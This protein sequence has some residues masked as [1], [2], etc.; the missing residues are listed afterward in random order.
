[1]KI[2]LP[3]TNREVVVDD[4][5]AIVT[6]TDL[7]G[8]I[9]FVNPD[10]IKISGY[11]EQELLGQN[12]NIVRH[13]DMPPAAFAD[14]W[15][16]MD[17]GKPWSGIVKN[18]C[19]NGDHYWVKAHVA[20][21]DENGKTVGYTSMRTKPGRAEIEA[22][23]RLYDAI[24]KGKATLVD[25]KVTHGV[26]LSK[27]NVLQ[28]VREL[29]VNAQITLM[30]VSFLA[31]F[32]LVSV[33]GYSAISQVQVTGPIYKRVVQGKDLIADILPPPEYLIEA[34]QVSLDMMNSEESALPAM[35]EKSRALR[36][37]YESRHQFWMKDLPEGQLKT[38]MVSG[39]YTPGEEF[40]D[41][42]DKR[43]IPALLAGNRRA[44]EEAL[45]MM[46]KKYAEHRAMIDKVVVLA[47]QRNS[48]DEKDAAE[49]IGSKMRMLG[50][51]AAAMLV[52]MAVLGIT[53][54][55]NINSLLGGDPRYAREI[56]RHVASG[57]LALR[58]DIDPNDTNSLLASIK[59]MREMFRQVVKSTQDSANQVAQV[60]QQMAAASEQVNTIARQ[61]SESTASMAATTEEMT[62][63]MGLVV[64]NAH[65]AHSISVKS[66]E[67]CTSGVE[68]IQQAVHSMEQIAVTVR[69]SAE[70][71]QALGAQSEQISSVVKVIR[72]IADQTNLLALNAA[73][74]AARAG[75]QGRGFAV[76][77]DEVRKLAERTT[78]ATKD[79]TTMIG[80]I[81]DGMR[82][83]VDNMERGVQQVNSGV[84]EANEAGEAIHQ[85]QAGAQRVVQVVSDMSNSLREQGKASE[86]IAQSLEE[87]ARMTEENSAVAH[88]ASQGAHQLLSSAK[89]MQNTVNRF[90]A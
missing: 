61:S 69:E 7:K 21:M 25:G 70:V 24:N 46:A 75:E 47:N 87:I 60:A 50:T 67:V 83:V 71:V 26:W 6:K 53:I 56:T 36:E 65:E 23:S 64:E 5:I 76:V 17:R 49:V 89:V 16:S 84:S 41:L 82:N 88:E 68:V 77:A 27:L 37:D 44:A 13:P 54:A 3:V 51:L 33:L 30:L 79:I 39:T 43:F 86:E 38:L 12:H 74:E 22:A 52:A 66:E 15:A 9:T 80:A 42:R 19:K 55:R 28:M 78:N 34:Y 8:I 18:R 85:I 90:A 4:D 45:S 14:L 73:I 32:I 63:S 2:N 40:L 62:V 11:S 20:P 59:Y 57:N 10:F 29:S 48:D 35:V 31:S 81:Q 58:I 1:M 72:E